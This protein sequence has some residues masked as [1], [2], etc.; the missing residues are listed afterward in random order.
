MKSRQKYYLIKWP[1]SHPY[2][3]NP[4]CIQ[5]EGMDYFVP[6]ELFDKQKH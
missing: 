6:C 1:E 4:Q 3:K 5:S 2:F